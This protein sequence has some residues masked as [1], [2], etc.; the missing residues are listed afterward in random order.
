M[1][2]NRIQPIA[3]SANERTISPLP[4]PLLLR[5]PLAWL[6]MFGPGAI[7]ASLTIGT[8]ELIFSTR[9]G[10]LFGYRIL[11]LFVL[12]SMLKWALVFAMSRQMVISGVHPCQRLMD[13]PGPRGWFPLMLLVLAAA[14]IPV[15]VGFHSGVLG[16]LTSWVTGTQEHLNGGA[17]YV[18]GSLFLTGAIA[19]SLAGGYSVMERV[20][21]AIVVAMVV[22]AAATLVLYQPD[23]LEM[24]KGTLL[25][26]PYHYP[27]W[28]DRLYPDIARQPV[29]IEITRY[30]GVIGGGGFD[31]LAYVSFLR[32]KHWGR[33]GTDEFTRAELDR[34]AHDPRHPVR[35]WVRAPLVDCTVSFLVVVAFSA[36]FVASGVVVL[37]PNHQLPTED[38]W[39]NLQARFVTSIHPYL[40]PLYVTGAFLTMLGTLYGTIE[41]AHVIL[42]EI[43]HAYCPAQPPASA[44]KLKVVAV[45]WCGVLAYA[46]LMGGLLYTW[47][48]GF[49]RPRVLLAIL[50]PANLFTGVLLCGLLCLLVRW[51]DVTGLPKPL[52]MPA[53]LL[54]LNL[55]AGVVFLGLGLKG[56]WDNHQ[57]AGPW[58]ASRWFAMGVILAVATASVA[59]AAASGRRRSSA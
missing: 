30:V 3:V 50:T 9:G 27:P 25:P 42:R 16:N 24:L 22:C 54:L 34:I 51:M 21:L 20:Q 55:V 17:D 12:V 14:T 39:L 52:R 18:W 13:L 35:Q 48:G 28:L 47:R 56:Y 1:D 37:G 36:V 2:L 5:N 19:L 11:F 31:Y 58:V 29:W 45:T 7:I 41:V 10:V 8:G 57:P 23:W 26:Q 4:A 33:A 46:V 53:W 43:V 59:L 32:D 44:R 15:W 40:L 6:A 38:N 49:Q